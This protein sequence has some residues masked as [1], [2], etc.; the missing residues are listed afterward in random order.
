ML[1]DDRSDFILLSLKKYLRSVGC[2]TILFF[3]VSKT[4][5]IAELLRSSLFIKL[6]FKS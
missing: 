2:N 6:F 5:V 1:L 4:K 3:Y